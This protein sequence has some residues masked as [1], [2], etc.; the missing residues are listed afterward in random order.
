MNS[1]LATLQALVGANDPDTIQKALTVTTG[2]V[3]I[4]LEPVAKLMLPLYAGL[5]NRLP[6]DKPKMGGQY[7]QWRMQLGY[8]T[9]DFA[10]A[11]GTAFGGVGS[12][13]TGTVTNIS[14]AYKSQAIKGSVQFEAIPMAAGWDDPLAI[15]T[16]R[17]LATLIRLEELLTLGGNTAALTSPSITATGSTPHVTPVFAS[18]SY[19]IQV[20]ALTLQGAI[21]NASSNSNVGESAPIAA[22][23]FYSGAS[24]ADWI[25]LNFTPV[26]GAVGYKVYMSS[27]AGGSTL[28]LVDPATQMHYYKTLAV[29]GALPTVPTGQTFITVSKF[30]V[31]ALPAATVANAAPST[32]GSAN[33]NAAEGLIAWAEK[34]TVYSQSVGTHIKYD[35][36]G[37]NLTTAGSGVTE[38]DY[39]LQNLWIKQQLSPSLIVCSPQSASHLTT[40]VL[41][42]NSSAMYRVELAPERGQFIGG[43]YIGGYLNKFAA[44]MLGNQAANIPVWAHPYMV[45]GTYLFLTERIPYQYSREAR[46]FAL[47]VQTPY[48]YFELARTDRSFPFSTF[49]TECLKC[50]HPLAN[51]SIAGVKVE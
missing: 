30:S 24:G 28:Y 42:A 1:D 14:A 46:G 34:S 32:D 51:A 13:A 19:N 48:T 6:V 33:A 38:F 44:S 7:A 12:D 9:F 8:G 50:Y 11:Q 20:T 31:F 41:A 49:F 36:A 25:V 27:V 18:G 22:T 10:G 4:N 2:F 37:A 35:C 45:D 16:S 29:D 39:I 15:E 40:Q 5:R 3:G 17:S 23:S 43:M 21:A 47:D 26:E